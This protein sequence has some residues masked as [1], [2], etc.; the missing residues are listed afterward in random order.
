MVDEINEQTSSSKKEG[1]DS[2]SESK[3]KTEVKKLEFTQD[4]LD[5][6]F[7]ERQKR[8]EDAA[9]KRFQKQIDDLNSQIEEFKG[10][11]LGELDKL[12]GKV[13]KLTKDLA[14]KDTEL[15]GKDLKLAKLEA[16]L[17]AGIPSAK[18]P[19]LLK[20]VAGTTPE[21]IQSDVLELIED[22]KLVEPEPE[23]QKGAKGAGHQQPK[24]PPGVKTFTRS[25]IK[26]M[27]PEEYDKNRDDIM[28]SMESGK[29]VS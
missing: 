6:K 13:E 28:K 9:A 7:A 1:D 16:L 3:T 2:T 10:K 22:L 24:D 23:P 15:S 8:G 12:K 25:Q 17:N 19:K 29:I 18:I 11:D 5:K 27:S 26:A 20:R 21:E 4:E 14:T